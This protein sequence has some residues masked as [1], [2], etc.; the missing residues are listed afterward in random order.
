LVFLRV[1]EQTKTATLED[2]KK[3]TPKQAE[4][5]NLLELVSSIKSAGT[6][7]KKQ[8][9]EHCESLLSI[10]DVSKEILFPSGINN[11]TDISEG[12]VLTRLLFASFVDTFEKYLSDLLYEIF[13]A[14]PVTLKAGNKT[15]LVKDVLDCID[16]DDFVQKE[17]KK[18]VDKL[19]RG[20]VK[21]FVEENQQINSLK[22]FDSNLISKTEDIFQIR[23]LFTHKNGIIDA[24]FINST[25]TQ[26][27]E[28]EEFIITIKNVI[29]DLEFMVD[30]CDKVDIAAI[31]KFSLSTV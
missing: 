18:R 26:Q 7:S 15:A 16:I 5:N 17:A 25:Q 4:I 30:L 2:I 22:I 23:H 3:I 8:Y 12:K 13:L 14:K 29:D 20:S 10:I 1:G 9:L 24:K 11:L 19:Q 31:A 28:G 6:N 27:K 21:S